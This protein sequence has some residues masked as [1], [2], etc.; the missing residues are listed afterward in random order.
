MSPIVSCTE[1]EFLDVIGTKVLKSFPS[2]YS[3]SHLPMDFTPTHPLPPPLSKSGLKLVC[4]VIIVYG[5][6]SLKTLKIMP[7][8]LNEIVHE[9]GFCSSFL[10]HHLTCVHSALS[11]VLLASITSPT[12][13]Y[14]VSISQPCVKTC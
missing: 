13:L 4:N 8:N 11:R 14:Y 10:S 12:P 6:L 3:Q 5:N 7:R 1:A 9:F 2:Y